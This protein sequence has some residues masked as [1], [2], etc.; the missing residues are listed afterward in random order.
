MPIRGKGAEGIRRKQELK[1]LAD[2]LGIDGIRKL[3]GS[4]E[5]VIIKKGSQNIDRGYLADYTLVLFD[6]Q[7]PRATIDLH[8]LFDIAAETDLLFQK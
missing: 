7:E 2:D 8:V 4:Y 1:R 3:W 6:G 5:V